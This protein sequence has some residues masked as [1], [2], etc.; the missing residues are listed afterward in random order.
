MSGPL[1]SCV[2]C[3]EPRK[4]VLAEGVK[5]LHLINKSD[6]LNPFPAFHLIK[7]R[8]S[9]LKQHVPLSKHT[10]KGLQSVVYVTKGMA[11][12]CDQCMKSGDVQH[13]QFGLDTH[14][15]ELP[16]SEDEVELFKLWIYSS[17]IL[18]RISS[19]THSSEDIS[20]VREEDNSAELRIL[21]GSVNGLDGPIETEPSTCF[22]DLT[23]SQIRS[24]VTEYVLPLPER[25]SSVLVYVYDSY[26][27]PTTAVVHVLTDDV[28][29]STPISLG[30]V[31]VLSPHG[32]SVKFRLD[33]R[34]PCDEATQI[35]LVK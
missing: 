1:R 35:D 20:V 29:I 3:Y 27:S 2:R 6:T 18:T 10:H 23:L 32:E 5:C 14:R 21:A 16:V 25:Y 24:T 26:P 8:L 19:C 13:T 22:F 12:S 30:S 34:I 17:S 15:S 7:L 4:S 11:L 31:A 33:E 28:S 9:E